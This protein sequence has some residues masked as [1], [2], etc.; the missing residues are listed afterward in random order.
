MNTGYLKISYSVYEV[1]AFWYIFM[2]LLYHFD[3][4]LSPDLMLIIPCL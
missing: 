4:N 1:G 3:Q 2:S